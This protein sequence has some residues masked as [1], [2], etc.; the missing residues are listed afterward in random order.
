MVYKSICIKQVSLIDKEG[1][2]ISESYYRPDYDVEIT[3]INGRDDNE[4]SILNNIYK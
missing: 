3:D 1:K 4:K 2:I